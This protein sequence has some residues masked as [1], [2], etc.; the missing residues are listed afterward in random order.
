[1]MSDE[2]LLPLPSVLAKL[3]EIYPGAGQEIIDRADEIAQER[4]RHESMAIESA[5]HPD[6][7]TVR[8]IFRQKSGQSENPD[9]RAAENINQVWA[10]VGDHLRLAILEFIEERKLISSGQLVLNDE[11]SGS[12][13]LVSD[14]YTE[15][16]EL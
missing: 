15:T 8:S 16:L 12:L 5:D 6:H 9:E 13:K 10:A 1:M 2:K 14:R 11:E 4:H 3:N 7:E